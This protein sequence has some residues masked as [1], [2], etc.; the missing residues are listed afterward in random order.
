MAWSDAVG[1]AS[2]WCCWVVNGCGIGTE[3]EGAVG[4]V[5]RIRS[6]D[7]DDGERCKEWIRE[8]SE[9]HI[10]LKMCICHKIPFTADRFYLMF[11]MR[12]NA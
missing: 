1:E 3:G 8:V 7:C 9:I 12:R 4:A 10:S 5:N 11:S 6:A 2:G